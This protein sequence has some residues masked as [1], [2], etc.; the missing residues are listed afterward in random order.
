GKRAKLVTSLGFDGAHEAA[1]AEIDLSTPKGSSPWPMHQVLAGRKPLVVKNLGH[2]SSALPAGRWTTPPHTAAVLPLSSPEQATP[3]GVLIC[4]LN[5]HRLLDE[6]YLGFFELAAQQVVTSI[7][8][9]RALEEQRQRAEALAEIDRAKTVFFSNVSHEFRTPLTLM[10]G[11]LQEALSAPPESSLEKQREGL[12]TAHQNALRLLKLTN[13]LLDF[14]RIEAGRVQ[15]SYEPIDLASFTAELASVFRSTVERAGLRLRVQCPALPERLYVDRDMWEKVVL[16]LL[17]NAFKFTFEGEIAV[18]LGWTGDGAELVVRDTGTGIPQDQLSHLFVRFNRIRDAKSRSYE[19]SGIGLALIQEL[20]R[21]HGG[22]VSVESTL[23]KGSTFRVRIPSGKAHLPQEHVRSEGHAAPS[24]IGT[25]PFVEEARRWL[26]GTDVVD[27]GSDAALPSNADRSHRILVA[28]DNAD[29]RAYLSRLLSRFWTVEAVADGN[30]ALRHA[31]AHPPDLILTDVMMPGMDGMDLIRELRKQPSTQEIPVIVLSARAGDEARVEGLKQG[32]GDYLVKPFSV[33]ELLA[34]VRAQLELSRGRA[35]TEQERR[36][37]YELLM[38]SPAPIAVFRG[39]DVVF[40]LANPSY[41]GIV[42]RTGAHQLVGKPLTQALPELAGQG[43]DDLLRSVMKDGKPHVGKETLARLDRDGDG[44]AEDTY[45][46]FIYSPLRSGDGVID[47]AICMASDVTDQVAARRA[48]ESLNSELE[49]RVRER[50]TS[51]QEMVRELDTF[52][53]TV[54]H[55]LRAPLRSIHGLSEMVMEEVQGVA[56]PNV[57]DYLHRIRESGARM[58]RL[59]RDLLAYSRVSREAITIQSIDMEQLVQ[60]VKY[61]ISDLLTPSKATILADGPFHDVQGSSTALGQALENLI[62]N[63]IKF[64][65]PGVHPHVTIRSEKVGTAVRLWVEDNGIGIPL[66]HQG[67]LFKV[68]E[69]LTTGST[70]PR[71]GIGLSIVHRAL[72]R[73][74]GKV[75]VE[76]IPGKGSRFWVELPAIPNGKPA[77]PGR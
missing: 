58:D 11:P 12:K 41:V 1:P 73:M 71:T 33:P 27:P 48:M 62:L 68:F 74:G 25:A 66:E 9:S 70:Y 28:D 4:G 36:Q 19:G 17:S 57:Q 46:T 14:A 47:R 64:V 40:E 13:T 6:G 29:M 30:S 21:L 52:A 37:L 44:V 5:P 61:R 54:A 35:R 18:S 10:L 53:Y 24:A 7:R 76:S 69:R 16:N 32:A 43:F 50:T 65:A 45:W 75:G 38:Q 39:P 34:R 59:I 31:L 56:S 77:G 63:A 51:L 2:L 67:R 23:G 60:D 3:Y 8:N 42:G 72:E 49:A 55:D 26:P 20:V 22:T 15:A